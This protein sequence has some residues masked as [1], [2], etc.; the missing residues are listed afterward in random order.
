MTKVMNSELRSCPACANKRAASHGFK[1]GF[2]ILACMECRTLYT[3][4]LPAAAEGENYDEY[5][6]DAN[7]SVPEFLNQRVEEIVG[8]FDGFRRTNRLLDIGFGSG[9]LLKAAAKLGWGVF[10]QEVSRPAVEQARSFGFEVFHG[11][12]VEAE[13]PDSHFDVV[14]ASE[15]IEHLPDPGVVLREVARILR[16]GGL[17]WATTPFARSLSFRLMKL[18]WSILSPP[19]HVQLYSKQGMRRML[20]QAGFHDIKLKTYGLN[21]A[22]IVHFY[23]SKLGGKHPNPDGFNRVEAGYELN[24]RLMRSPVKRKIKS[25]LNATLDFA[26]LGDSMKIYAIR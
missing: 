21:P 12:L 1:F 8:G 18:E 19:E 13:Y 20:E 2:E 25:V 26:R 11:D 7:L 10:G 4:H 15:I 23:R 17:L 24:E 14:T 3:D 5:Y 6:T 16:P 9:Y 22:E